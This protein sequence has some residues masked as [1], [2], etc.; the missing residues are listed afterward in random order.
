V[1]VIARLHRRGRHELPQP[2]LTV[3]DALELARVQRTVAQP[4]DE[5]LVLPRTERVDWRGRNLGGVVH[6]SGGT[7][8]SEPL[9]AVEVDGLRPYRIGAPASRIHWAALAR[10]AGLLE[11]RLRADADTRPL[12]VL[13][14]RCRD[15]EAAELDA[16][17]RAA[18]SLTLE[19]ARAGGC[20]LLLPDDR[21]ALDVD[22]ELRAWPAAHVR[23]ALVEGG[24]GA[25]PPRLG[26]GSRA[27]RIFYVAAQPPQRLGQALA[28]SG[29]LATALVLPAGVAAGTRGALAF[30]VAGCRGYL[31][32]A[33]R[34]A[35][36]RRQVA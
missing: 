35:D 7:A 12:V 2:T 14:A 36:A 31:L 8:A 25:P 19:L 13:D 21:R 16:A 6:Q 5:V 3:R 18:A 4:P 26:H 10:G 30:E 24:P 23:L 22:P 33:G 28:A 17:V 34:R 15:P 29:Q 9:A 11:R 1:N 20:G 32:A 27:G